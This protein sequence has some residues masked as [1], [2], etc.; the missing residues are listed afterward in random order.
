MASS[1]PVLV[2]GASGYLASWIVKLL[3][4]DGFSVRGTVRNLGDSSKTEHLRKLGDQFPGKLTLLE[5]DLLVEGSFDTAAAGCE[6]IYHVASPFIVGKI[7]NPQ[8]VLVDPALKGTRNVLGS[9]NRTASVQRVVLT[10]SVVTLYGDPIDIRKTKNG[11]FTEEDWNT[12][13]TLDHEPY[14]LSKVLAEKEAW[15]MQKAQNR[16]DL[17]TIHPGF[18][19][20]PAVSNR[21]DGASAGFM[22]DLL[23]GKYRTGSADLY[24]TIVD[25]RDAARLHILAGTNP[26]AKGRYIASAGTHTFTEMAKSI[27]KSFPNTFPLPKTTIPKALL[28]LVGPFLGLSWKM[29]S[30]SIGIPVS[31]DNH[32]SVKELGLPY[33]PLDQTYKDHIERLLQDGLVKPK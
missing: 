16:W 27:E 5:A 7:S 20:G 24:F 28:Y 6:V 22:L 31:F 1:S 23:R 30:R 11:V 29:I 9:A 33:R 12:T 19:L 13:S 18:V 26:A 8:K 14:R 2:T 17:V 15:A 32:R 21:D 10:A 25:V 3:L 4:E